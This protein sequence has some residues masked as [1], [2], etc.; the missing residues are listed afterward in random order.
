MQLENPKIYYTNYLFVSYHTYINNVK[1]SEIQSFE[2]GVGI[3][4][5]SST[6]YM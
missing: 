2:I 1:P 3:E 6:K 5:N 4:K